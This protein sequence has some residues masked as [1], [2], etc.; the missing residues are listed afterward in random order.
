MAGRKQTERVSIMATS[1]AENY[2]KALYHACG[3]DQQENASTGDIA[4][5]LGLTPGSVTGM[6]KRMERAGLV[7]YT[8][9]QGA[10]LTSVGRKTALRI[11]RRHRL[12]ELFLVESLGMGWDEVHE[13][14]ELLEHSASDRL[15]DR[16][17]QHLGYPDRDPHGDPIPDARGNVVTVDGIPLGEC[18]VGNLFVVCQVDDSSEELLRFLREGGLELGTTG[19]VLRAEPVA[20]IIEIEINNRR[21][22]I[23][24]D[25]SMKILVRQ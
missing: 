2:L 9:H 1:T 21:L 16:I 24:R 17:D 15:I 3:E 5:R 11:I 6:L 8:P 13:E 22:V 18:S 10:R 19:K 7:D 4:H 23:G 25:A 12:L 20:G 14:A